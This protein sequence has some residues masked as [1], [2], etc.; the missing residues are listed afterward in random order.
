MLEAAP[1]AALGLALP[2][3]GVSGVSIPWGRRK[4]ASEDRRLGDRRWGLGPWCIPM[5]HFRTRDGSERYE[6]EDQWD[7]VAHEEQEVPE[8]QVAGEPVRAQS[9]Q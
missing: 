6:E 8:F 2:P 3:N 1:E 9:Y 7:R 5:H 4:E